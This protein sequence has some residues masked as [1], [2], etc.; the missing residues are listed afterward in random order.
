M[1]RTHFVHEFET[2]KS[3]D[4]PRSDKGRP[5]RPYAVGVASGGVG[6]FFRRRSS[7]STARP[8]V[9]RLTPGPPPAVSQT[10]NSASVASGCWLTQ[11]TG[12]VRAWASRRGR[13]AAVGQRSQRTTR[14]L[15]LQERG[16]K[17]NR[18][19]ELGRHRA[20][21]A[22]GLVTGHCDTFAQVK[23]IGSHAEK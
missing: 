8:S 6:P 3:L 9:A 4:L 16:H 19:A 1:C 7:P 5:Q 21:C 14:A 12:W 15:A 20:Y 11:A 10:H 22:P 18:H 23:R 2:G 17:R 13:P